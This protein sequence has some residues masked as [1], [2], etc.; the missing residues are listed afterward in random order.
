MLTKSPAIKAIA[1][2]SCALFIAALAALAFANWN[3]TTPPQNLTLVYVGADDCAPCK[4]WQRD[5]RTAFRESPEF[6]QLIYR[7]VKSPTL[8]DVLNDGNWP[9]ELRIYRRAIGR[10]TGVPLWL[11]VADDRIVLRSS[12]LSQWQDAVLPK[13]ASLLR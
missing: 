10:G 13:I 8:F 2:G 4:T 3:S 5:Q 7:E 11:V 1:A 6:R 9:E 12:G